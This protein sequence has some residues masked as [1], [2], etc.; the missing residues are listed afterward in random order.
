MKNDG[1]YSEIKYSEYS[2]TELAQLSPLIQG[3][4]SDA[5]KEGK[6]VDEVVETFLV[7][8]CALFDGRPKGIEFRIASSIIDTLKDRFQNISPVLVAD[9][10]SLTDLAEVKRL[11]NNAS[12]CQTL[13]EFEAALK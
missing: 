13:A 10:L 3:I 12:T 2:E 6:D 4:I 1:S 7:K 5:K 9:V 8:T 11:A